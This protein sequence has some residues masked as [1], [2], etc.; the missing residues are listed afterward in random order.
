MR[1]ALSTIMALTMA[2]TMALSIVAQP[3]HAEETHD[4][5]LVHAQ[6]ADR[7]EI[8]EP[9]HP[10]FDAAGGGGH[11]LRSTMLPQ[12]SWMGTVKWMWT[13]ISLNFQPSGVRR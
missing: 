13:I 3:A 10:R 2:L 12:P 11:C 8:F 6:A 4:E 7:V 9:P 1:C 5:L